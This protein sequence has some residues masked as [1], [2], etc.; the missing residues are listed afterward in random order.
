VDSLKGKAELLFLVTL[1]KAANGS[2]L[3][4]TFSAYRPSNIKRKNDHLLQPNESRNA[5]DKCG[6]LT[7]KVITN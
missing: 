2:L 4:E 1:R 6:G 3:L 7:I 5:L